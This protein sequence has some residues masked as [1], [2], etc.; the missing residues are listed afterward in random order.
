MSVARLAEWLWKTDRR[1]H[2]EVSINTMIKNFKPPKWICANDWHTDW[3]GGIVI[4]LSKGHQGL[5]SPSDN[6]DV[7]HL[8]TQ[9]NL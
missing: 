2:A 5:P 7:A 4:I 1:R 3:H 6:G 8:V 9:I